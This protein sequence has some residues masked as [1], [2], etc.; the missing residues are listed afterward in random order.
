M[1]RSAQDAIASIERLPIPYSEGNPDYRRG[2]AAAL[3]RVLDILTA[4]TADDIGA[5]RVSSVRSEARRDRPLY[6]HNV[7]VPAD[8]NRATR[9]AEG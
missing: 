4:A 7:S 2:Y 6:A 3:E 8:T 9:A 1:F 5:Q